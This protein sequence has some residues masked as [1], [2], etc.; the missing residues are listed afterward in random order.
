VLS[1][2]CL[3]ARYF[4]DLGWVVADEVILMPLPFYTQRWL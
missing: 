4:D 3:Q 1:T 2:L